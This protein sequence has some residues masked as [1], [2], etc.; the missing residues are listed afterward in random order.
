M[1]NPEAAFWKRLGPKGH[2]TA[3]APEPEPMTSEPTPKSTTPE[4]C[5]HPEEMRMFSHNYRA[6]CQCGAVNVCGD[7]WGP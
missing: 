3:A 1:P 2:Q 4:P 7:W 6:R 5:T